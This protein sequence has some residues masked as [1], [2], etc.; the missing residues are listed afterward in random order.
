M[1]E[2]VVLQ[3]EHKDLKKET[4]RAEILQSDNIYKFSIRKR[5][6]DNE[7]NLN[8]MKSVEVRYLKTAKGC[9]RSGHIKTEDVRKDLS[10]TSTQKL[11]TRTKLDK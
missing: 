5:I 2:Y 7:K 11:L 8:K 3:K 10:A 4:Y 1:I 6:L 9:T